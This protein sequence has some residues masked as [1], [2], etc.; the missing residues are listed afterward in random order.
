VRQ[1]ARWWAEAMAET[2]AQTLS[3]LEMEKTGLI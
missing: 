1:F 2:Q 3:L